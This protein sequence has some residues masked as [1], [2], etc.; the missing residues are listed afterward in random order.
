MKIFHFLLLPIAIG[1]AALTVTACKD[2]EA[3]S[4]DLLRHD[5]NNATGPLLAAGFHELAVYFP[6]SEMAEFTGKKLVELQVFVGV[7]PQDLTLKVYGKGTAIAPG[8]VL[9][10][11]TITVS[12][13][14]TPDWNNHTIST[15]ITL[16]GDDIWI[17]VG[18]IHTVE[19]QSIGCD[20]GPNEA[21][22]DW[23]FSGSDSEWKTYTERTGESVNWNLRA[24]IE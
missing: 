19:Q 3:P 11:K 16:D 15:P 5:G 18:V 13:L 8:A 12:S 4:S 21:G 1:I 24:R 10:E 9:Y 14:T 2:D 20:S 17:A 22:G 6:A 7:K 23:L